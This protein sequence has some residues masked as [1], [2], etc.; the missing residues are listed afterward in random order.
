MNHYNNRP[1]P[2]F[3]DQGVWLPYDDSEWR[4]TNWGEVAYNPSLFDNK[5]IYVLGQNQ[6]TGEVV[7]CGPHRLVDAGMRKLVNAYGK[8]FR[9]NTS[10]V[11]IKREKG[12]RIK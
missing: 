11:L 2:V 12:D 4:A 3:S 5:D 8:V 6:T 7:Y 1:L 10:A 9:D